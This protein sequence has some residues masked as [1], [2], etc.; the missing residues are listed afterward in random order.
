MI[1]SGASAVALNSKTSCCRSSACMATARHAAFRFTH[2][3]QTVDAESAT[4][5][6]ASGFHNEDVYL[7]MNHSDTLFLK[8]SRH[9]PGTGLLHGLQA[10]GITHPDGQVDILAYVQHGH[11]GTA[12]FAIAWSFFLQGLCNGA[13]QHHFFYTRYLSKRACQVLGSVAKVFLRLMCLSILLQ[14]LPSERGIR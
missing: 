4:V 2:G 3:A 14:Y 13:E 12:V 8:Q 7:V 1:L 9:C 11:S 5:T 10:A 6:V